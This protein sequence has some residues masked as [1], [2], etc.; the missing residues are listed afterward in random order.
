[1]NDSKYSSN[2][3]I[4]VPL[5]FANASSITANIYCPFLI[6]KVILKKL[7]GNMTPLT[8]VYNITSNIPNLGYIGNVSTIVNN[9][10]QEHAFTFDDSSLLSLN[11]TYTFYCTTLAG[12]LQAY[13]GSISLII[14][15]YQ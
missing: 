8:D 2:R 7:L 5:L 11:G 9:Q 1:M 14:E 10:I 13:N 3:V 15:L 6:R 12:A 4:N